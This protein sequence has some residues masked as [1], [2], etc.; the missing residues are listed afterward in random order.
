MV[1]GTDGRR[2]MTCQRRLKKVELSRVS[3]RQ[4]CGWLLLVPL[5]VAEQEKTGD[6]VGWVVGG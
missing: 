1:A 2:G 6:E 5:G 3:S 4:G